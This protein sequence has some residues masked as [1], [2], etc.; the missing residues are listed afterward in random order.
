[1]KSV[2]VF[3]G[4]VLLPLIAAA[5]AI[6][7][8]PALSY[9][10]F[11]LENGLTVVVH[12]DH[13]A[14]IV[15]LS[16]WY[17][18]GSADEPDGKTGFAHL[19]EHLMFSGSENHKGTYFQPFEQAG[20]SEINGTTWFDRTN[21]FE[22]VPSSALDMALWMESDRM[23]HLLGAVDQNALDSQR[24]VVQNEKREG[25]N[26]PYGR[27]EAA[28]LRNLYPSNHPYHHE[29]VGSMADLDAASLDDVKQWFHDFYGA[30]NTTLVL[31]GD[32]T[33]TQAREKAERYFGDIPAGPPVPRQ[34]PW[35]APPLRVSHATLYDHV[36]Q[37]R[38]VQAWMV[39]P[40]GSDDCI[41]LGLAARILGSSAVSRLF[42]SLVVKDGLADDVT[43]SIEPFAL[44][45]TFS[46][47]VDVRSGVK[48]DRVEAA[49]NAELKKF[50]AEGPTQDE[51]DRANM[52]NYSGFVRSLERVGSQAA[53]LAEG[54]VY[55]DEPLNYRS[56]LQR[57]W[58]MSTATVRAMSDKWLNR[59]SVFVRVMP[60]ENKRRPTSDEGAARGVAP[61]RPV[62]SVPPAV[63]WRTVASRV[64]RSRG[65]PAVASF[66]DPRFP[67]VERGRLKNGIEVQLVERHDVPVTLVDLL[68]RGGF[69]ADHDRAS[70]TTGMA[71][72][73]LG[74]GAGRLD[75]VE[76]QLRL[77][78]LGAWFH[79]V[80]ALDSCDVVLSAQQRALAPSVELFADIVRH[81][82]FDKEDIE[83]ARGQ[84]L[85]DIA[86]EKLDQRGIA[87]RVVPPLLY[88]HGH[89]YAIPF[90]GSGTEEGI[91][92]L[93]REA[94][95][96]FQ[97]DY[98]RPDN[99]LILVVGDTTMQQILPLLDQRLGDWRPGPTPVPERNVAK[100]AAPRQARVFLIDR[101]DAP[102]SLV[103][104]GLL[105]PPS[106]APDVLA[107]S[108]A[109]E[110]LCGSFTS[111]L[112]MNLREDKH[113]S[114][115]A[116]CFIPDALGQR[117]FVFYAPVQQDRTA[118]S[119]SAM[120]DELGDV[121]GRRPLTGEEVDGMKALRERALPGSIETSSEVMAVLG[122]N[123]L[124]ARPDDYLSTLGAKLSALGVPQAEAALR[125]VLDPST[126]TWVIVG[127]LR[128]I[129]RPIRA[130][131]LG[132]VEVIDADGRR[133]R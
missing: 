55:F 113:W 56:S 4:L 105:A 15:A 42:Q 114:Y 50:L 98:L 68:L 108:L 63:A 125:R 119:V 41:A 121:V 126:L 70:G 12:E 110:A 17:H 51:L 77:Q 16:I 8:I 84:H 11:R 53:V 33:P 133:V 93:T 122:D 57:S 90:E 46:V 86:Q 71:V 30:A 25:D 124:Y 83:L 35:V 97:Q 18:V 91:R 101:P 118:E 89:A 43:V 20:A 59:P 92:S 48:P 74:E 32:V 1:M 28:L 94:M 36:S 9:T 131:N 66:P 104:A 61:G 106:T 82:A 2:A 75:S 112:N 78:R 130:L 117:P 107:L 44:A 10:R 115:G 109:S 88:G 128:H 29:T 85:S 64:D 73:L 40:Q 60:V 72:S 116:H 5:R 19:F 95:L 100:V 80:C 38:I 26:Q 65:V 13:K 14:P 54:Q 132:P 129:E 37:P 96:R 127:D 67:A 87:T 45:S 52:D 7:D 27:V 111:R 23:G 47:T 81:P 79:A 21:Y 120:R 31:A 58:D 102:Q 49:M 123:A 62:A 3:A 24:G 34:Q 103:M 22:T 69:A 99:A 76:V 6:P 39:P